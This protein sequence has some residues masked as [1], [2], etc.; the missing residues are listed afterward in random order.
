VSVPNSGEARLPDVG[1]INFRDAGGHQ[2]TSGARVRSGRLFRSVALDDASN[3]DLGALEAAGVMTVFDMRTAEERERRPDRLPEGA[4]L[5]VVDVLADDG[6]ADYHAVVAHLREPE[7]LDATLEV[8]DLE[9]FNVASYRDFVR[10]GSAR[11]SYGRFYRELARN[12]GAF[13]V[14]CTGGKDR[15]GWGVA[16]LMTFL[17]VPEESVLEDYLR[18][19]AVIRQMF[20]PMM[21]DYVSRGGRREVVERMFSARA[22]FLASA[23]ATVAQDHGSIEAYFSEG[24]GLEDDVLEAL[25]ASF[26]E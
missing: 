11:D 6:D 13:L 17:G 18:S 9:Q 14:H 7:L 2:T 10:L 16:A 15:T 25:R 22:T 26:L 5:V 23:F 24:L 1:I 20:S 3:D 8:E 4:A 19:D 21:D 12:N